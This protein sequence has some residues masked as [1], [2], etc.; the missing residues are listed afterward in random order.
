M[1]RFAPF[2]AAFRKGM[3]YFITVGVNTYEYPAWN[4]AAQDSRRLQEVL[5]PRFKQI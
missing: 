3:A 1:R 2:P 5:G 4:L